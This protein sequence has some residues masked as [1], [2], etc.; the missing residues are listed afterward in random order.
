MQ[1]SALTFLALLDAQK[2]QSSELHLKHCP[3]V[4]IS[5]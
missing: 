1:Q 4:S 2:L 3:V 5:L